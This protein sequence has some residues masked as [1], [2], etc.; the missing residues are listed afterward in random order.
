MANSLFNLDVCGHG[1]HDLNLIDLFKK[2]AIKIHQTLYTIPL[3]VISPNTHKHIELFNLLVF[4]VTNF[5]IIFYTVNSEIFT[6]VLFSRNYVW[7]IST[8][9]GV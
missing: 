2:L 3:S 8:N 5:S 9:S 7:S 4:L 6:R 1:H